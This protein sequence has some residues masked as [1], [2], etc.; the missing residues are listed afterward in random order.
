MIKQRKKL[1]QFVLARNT[2]QTTHGQTKL[3]YKK[4]IEFALIITL[5]VLI[6]GFRL[7]ANIDFEKYLLNIEEVQFEF[8]DLLEIPPPIEPPQK[9]KMEEIIEIPP[10]PEKSEEGDDLTEEIEEMLGENEENVEL[11]LDSG[12]MG[13]YL[14]SSS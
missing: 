3:K 12:D 1:K 10:E 11:A 4:N 6:V 7:A 5:V 2:T 14:A 8:V 13:A 9:L